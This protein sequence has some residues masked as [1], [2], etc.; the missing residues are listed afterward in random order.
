MPEAQRL[1]PQKH[2]FRWTGGFISIILVSFV[3]QLGLFPILA[4]Y[5]GEFSIVGPVSNALVI[6][7]LT[8]IVPVGL[9]VI[10]LY[11]LHTE[12]FAIT[13]IPIEYMLGWIEGVATFTGGN[14]FS[15]ISVGEISI[16]VFLIWL[17]AVL[18]ISTL[19]IPKLRWKIAI[20]LLL[21]VN[22][23]LIEQ[24][25]KDSEPKKLRITSLDV[26]QGDAIHIETP[27]DKHLLVDAGRWSPG[28][29]SGEEVILPYLEENG[30]QK[31]DGVLLSHPH[32]DHIGGMEEIIEHIQVDTI[33][34]TAIDYESQLFA[35]YME[36]AK[37]ESIAIKNPVA[38]DIIQ[39]DPSIRIFIIGP[40]AGP[41]SSNINNH[42]L[43]FKLVY[44][45][46]SALF[47]GDAEKRQEAQLVSDYGNFLESD[48][49]KVGHH[50][51]N[52][53]STGSFMELVEPEITIA[54]LGFENRFRHPGTETVAR[55]HKY[56]E[57]Q[58]YTSL[59][60]AIMYESDG[61][62][63]R[64]IKWRQ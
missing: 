41:G 28:G 43:A 13:A 47:S 57:V 25:I 12:I 61:K 51:S 8:I 5:F 16:A 31:L 39:I 29:N 15:F 22:L 26:G 54:S 6:P 1:I 4:A 42:S 10:V 52:T 53:S 27:N 62:A 18:T 50:A 37:Q 38:G 45:N 49:Y 9:V 23:L 3:V 21:A 36:K 55:L 48:L 59:S 24:L 30:I 14:S 2:Q 19:R 7:L 35:R 56:S 60:G 33:Y 17:F 34:Q 58:N 63:F 46:T 32:A 20:G 40:N 44:G 11:S 64:K